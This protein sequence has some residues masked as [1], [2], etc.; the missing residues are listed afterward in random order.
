LLAPQTAAVTCSVECAG[1][2]DVKGTTPFVDF[3]EQVAL[4]PNING[5][6]HWGQQNSSN[7]QQIEFRFGGGPGSMAGRL[8]E[9]RSVLSRL[10]DN[11]RLDGFS[12]AFTRQTGLEIVQPIITS[13]AVQTAPTAASPQCDF[14]WDCSHNPIATTVAIQIA[15]PSGATQNVAAPPLAGNLTFATPSP[16]TYTVTLTASLTVNGETNTA[17]QTLNVPFA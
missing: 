15:Q 8:P 9:W 5:I 17:S 16:G 14:A 1:L 6:L 13:L 3:A 12:S 11:G 2:T 10:T 4:D 7:Q